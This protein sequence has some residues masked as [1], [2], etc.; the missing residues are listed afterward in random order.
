MGPALSRWFIYC[1]VISI[2]VAYLTGRVLPGGTSYLAVFRVAGAAAFL[3]YS[4]SVAMQSIWMGLPWST[5]GKNIFD[6]L[7]YALLTA[8]SFGWL[9]PKA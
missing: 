1:L 6:G 8:G 3:G 2:F 9:Y 7:V 4:G 5:T